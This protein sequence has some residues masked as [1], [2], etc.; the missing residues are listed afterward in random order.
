MATP[1][2]A[3]AGGEDPMRSGLGYARDPSSG[4]PAQLAVGPPYRARPTVIR[5][6]TLCRRDLAASGPRGALVLDRQRVR[7]MPGG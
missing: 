3:P 2:R 6:R 7:S 4:P 1:V 5:P